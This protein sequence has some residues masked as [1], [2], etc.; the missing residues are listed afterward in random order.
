M[1]PEL[2]TSVL[3][4]TLLTYFLNNG[5]FVKIRYFKSM[6]TEDDIVFDF[7]SKRDIF[8]SEIFNVLNPNA[9][10]FMYMHGYFGDVSTAREYC[11]KLGIKYEGD[12]NCIIVDWTSVAH[13]ANYV[14]V[15]SNLQKV[16]GKN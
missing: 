1:L 7:T 5:T 9:R 3:Y 12:V 16:S 6:N 4:S 14:Q 13:N 15:K 8:D 11:Q 2:L 10:T